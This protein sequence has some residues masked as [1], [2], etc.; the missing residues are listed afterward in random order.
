L[1]SDN[2]PWHYYF[3]DAYY[4]GIKYSDYPSTF[5]TEMIKLA[6]KCND[7]LVQI[8]WQLKSVYIS[9]KHEH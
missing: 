7:S 2:L 3:K 8:N 1:L 4:I 5:N 9:L 6:W